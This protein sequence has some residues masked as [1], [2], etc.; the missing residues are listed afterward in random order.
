MVH[1]LDQSD[2]DFET[3]FQAFLALKRETSVDVDAAAAQIIDDVRTGGHRAVA[4]YTWRFDGLDVAETA[5]FTADEIDAAVA[6]ADAEDRAALELAIGRIHAFHA[7]QRPNDEA[8]RDDTGVELGW[9]WTA[10]SAAGI[11]VPGGQAAY[12]S[13]VYMNAIPATVA[14]V[15][16]IAMCVPT[17]NGAVNDL[18][19]TAAHLCG[20]SEI[21]RVGGA[22]AVA[23]MAYGTEDVEPVDK[24]VGPGNAY[25]AAAKRRVFGQVGIDMIAG[26][27]EILV[28]ADSANDPAWIA[29]DLLSQAEHD[30][31]AQSILIADDA[32]FAQAVCN[33]VEA[34][35][36]SPRAA[37]KPG[38]ERWMLCNRSRQRLK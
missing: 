5:R 18:V 14:G 15:P 17:P 23:A 9:R 6:R 7:R 12:P 8:Y 1:W 3:T 4:N 13:S 20:V 38:R 22:Q 31:D 33:A 19:L 21:Y 24:V 30:A 29:A 11:Y 37:T 28:V 34:Q 25:V 27:S 36:Q 26:P 32:G 2:A 35:L 10:I 16:R